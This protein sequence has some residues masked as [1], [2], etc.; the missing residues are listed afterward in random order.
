MV[1]L[2]K[3]KEKGVGM[4]PPAISK[5]ND[6]TVK[7]WME[8]QRKLPVYLIPYILIADMIECF[9]VITS[10]QPYCL[11]LKGIELGQ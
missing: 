3:H 11:L 1:S 5:T 4:Y 2:I 9:N 7:I 10:R 6:L 8:F